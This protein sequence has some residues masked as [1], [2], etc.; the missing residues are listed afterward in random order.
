MDPLR[1]KIINI[2]SFIRM[3]RRNFY[4]FFIRILVVLD[5]SSFSP[6]LPNHVRVASILDIQVPMLSID[7][8]RAFAFSLGSEGL[9]SDR[10]ELH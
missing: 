9:T 6:L 5:K 7:A 4:F 3:R 1:G 10:L 8:A 2:F